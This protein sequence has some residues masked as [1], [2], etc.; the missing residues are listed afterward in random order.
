MICFLKALA[1]V[2][3]Q[4]MDVRRLER[5]TSSMS[6]MRSNQLSY[7]S[8]QLLNIALTNL[9]RQGSILCI[10]RPSYDPGNPTKIEHSQLSVLNVKMI[11]CLQGWP[12]GLGS[13]LIIRE[14]KL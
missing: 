14:R 4:P 5:R 8:L 1:A 11:Q 10:D 2:Y 13:G 7:T 12:I 6:T 9:M 3:Y